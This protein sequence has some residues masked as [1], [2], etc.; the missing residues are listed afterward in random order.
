MCLFIADILLYIN[1]YNMDTIKLHKNIV[2]YW[3]YNDKIKMGCYKNLIL[4]NDI[5][6]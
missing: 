6:N 3:K 1:E 2:Y 4:G 5:I